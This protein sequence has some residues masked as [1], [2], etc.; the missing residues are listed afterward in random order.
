MPQRLSMFPLQVE[1]VTAEK[2]GRG[3]SMEIQALMDTIVRIVKVSH[4]PENNKNTPRTVLQLYNCMWYHHE[5][6]QHLV[7]CPNVLTHKKL[8]GSNLHDISCHAGPQF[9]LV[10][11]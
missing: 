7:P 9:E 1:K 10:S 11:L 4:L 2:T 8:F 6:L 3:V 5:L